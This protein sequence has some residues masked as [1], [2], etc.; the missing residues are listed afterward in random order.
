MLSTKK[1]K[2][3]LMWSRIASSKTTATVKSVQTMLL[4]LYPASLQGAILSK[5]TKNNHSLGVAP[6]LEKR[7]PYAHENG[8]RPQ[9]IP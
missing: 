1:L 7:M 4:D 3:R 8:I 6:I 2:Q 5:K 9:S